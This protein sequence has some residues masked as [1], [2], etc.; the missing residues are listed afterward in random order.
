MGR[1]F[2]K[3]FFAY[4]L[5]LLLAGSGVGTAVWLYHQSSQ[6]TD[7]EIDTHGPARTFVAAAGA[8]LRY[9]GAQALRSLLEEWAHQPIPPVY[10]IDDSDRELLDRRLSLETVATARS[11]AAAGAHPEMVQQ[12]EATQGQ[13]YLIFV[14]RHGPGRLPPPSDGLPPNHRPPPHEGR[15]PPFI[16]VAAGV[17]ASIGFSA[18]LAWYLSKPIRNLRAAFAAVAAGRLDTRAGP[19]MGRRRDEIAD[20]GVDFDHMASQIGNLVAAQRRLLHDV[21]HELRSPLAR[22][23]AAI[24]LARQQPDKTADLLNRVEREAERLDGLVGELLTLSRLEAGVPGAET[25]CFDLAD[26]L[27]EIAEDAR[28]EGHRREIRLEVQAPPNLRFEG[29]IEPIHRAIENVIR[30]AI[31]HSPERGAVDIVLAPSAG[32]GFLLLTVQDRG[33]GVPEPQLHKIFEPFFRGSQQST[34]EG[35]GLGLAIA[36]LAVERHGGTIRADNRPGGGLRIEIRLP[37]PKRF[38]PDPA[39]EPACPPRAGLSRK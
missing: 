29:Q 30:N 15:P 38:A 17:L 35:S 19:T 23:Q 31:Q 36:R 6:E 3:F 11:M 5:A 7:R 1:L 32:A 12:V 33:S 28:F 9:G 25:E 27:A 10:A 21:S 37:M 13:H 18:W 8:T 2:W 39:S 20:L 14:T 34:R 26:L 4:W 16:P 24:G 22:L